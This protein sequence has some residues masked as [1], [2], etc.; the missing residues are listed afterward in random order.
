MALKLGSTD[1]NG[2][3]LGSTA[4]NA[5]YLGTTQIFGGGGGGGSAELASIS[6]GQAGNPGSPVSSVAITLPSGSTSGDRVVVFVAQGREGFFASLTESGTGWTEA[7]TATDNDWGGPTVGLYTKVLD[8]TDSLTIN[9][10]QSGSFAYIA[11]RFTNPG[12]F[13]TTTPTMVSSTDAVDPPSLDAGSSAERIWV[14][15]AASMNS[16]FAF[17]GF[18]SGYA[19]NQTQVQT[20]SGDYR[21][22]SIAVATRTTTAQTENPGTFARGS[23]NHSGSITFAVTR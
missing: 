6:T 10:D 9:S 23:A 5:A 13:H 19:D 1:I 17:T 22:I 12:T 15:C 4:I 14:A 21:A 3:Y 2:L 20:T 18:P 8:G 7:S 16:D 11:M